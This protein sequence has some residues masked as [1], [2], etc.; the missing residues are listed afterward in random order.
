MSYIQQ[1]EEEQAVQLANAKSLADQAATINSWPPAPPFPPS[2]VYNTDETNPFDANG[3]LNLNGQSPQQILT[4]QL[5]YIVDHPSDPAAFNLFAKTISA[6]VQA[7]NPDGSPMMTAAALQAWATGQGNSQDILT[8]L[9]SAIDLSATYAFMYNYQTDGSTNPT[10][11]ANWQSVVN[12]IQP[13]STVL[14]SVQS[15]IGGAGQNSFIDTMVN[16]TNW[17]LGNTPPPAGQLTFEQQFMQSH[18]ASSSI[19]GQ[20]DAGGYTIAAGDIVFSM[21]LDGQ[22]AYFDW[23]QAYENKDAFELNT[24]NDM[25]S[26]LDPATGTQSSTINGLNSIIGGIQGQ[27][28]W[29]TFVQ[30]MKMTGGDVGYAIMIAMD[31]MGNNTLGQLNGNADVMDKQHQAS[32]NALAIENYLRTLATASTARPLKE[33]L[34]C[35]FTEI[36]SLP[37]FSTL[38]PTVQSAITTLQTT[39]IAY[40]VGSSSTRGVWSLLTDPSISDASLLGALQNGL[41]PPATGSPPPSSPTEALQGV[42]G[43]IDS[44]VTAISSASS[45][46]TTNASQIESMIQAEAKVMT[47]VI[48]PNNGINTAVIRNTINHQ[49]GN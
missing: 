42:L 6:M 4:Y 10:A 36:S 23:T 3:N 21:Q 32:Q 41:T 48:D 25:A 29:N 17:I 19:V 22:T 35:L 20:T 9:Q 49:T 37:Q 11:P 13:L 38:S 46:A 43:A 1:I 28:F 2:G 44:I 27:D 5:S 45:Q 24:I 15:S 40:P 26:G 8:A 7:K 12:Y 34:L 33:N 30:A 14:Q 18:T 47:G 39:Q 16:E 31:E